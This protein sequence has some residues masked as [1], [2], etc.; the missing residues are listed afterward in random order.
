MNVKREIEAANRRIQEQINASAREALIRIG[1]DVDAMER[2]ELE[3][4]L[5]AGREV[6][7]A[8]GRAWGKLLSAAAHLA[9]A[10]TTAF[11]DAI[12]GVPDEAPI[13]H[14]KIEGGAS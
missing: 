11:A 1:V 10:F 5:E 7:A 13:V 12:G 4:R 14:E 3:A 6:F 8:A 2:E 9:D